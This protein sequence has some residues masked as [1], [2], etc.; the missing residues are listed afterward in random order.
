V[1][2]AKA[3]STPAPASPTPIKPIE[4]KL[5]PEEK[6]PLMPVEEA[7]PEPSPEQQ[8]EL[9][10][11]LVMRVVRTITDTDPLP[12]SSEE[13]IALTKRDGVELLTFVGDEENI[14]LRFKSEQCVVN[15]DVFRL[16]ICMA[17]INSRLPKQARRV[18]RDQ[19]KFTAPDLDGHG[20]HYRWLPLINDSWEDI[21][22]ALADEKVKATWINAIQLTKADEISD[23]S[24]Q[25]YQA[26]TSAEVAPDVAKLIIA[27][28]V[29]TTISN[30]NTLEAKLNVLER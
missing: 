16:A 10:S 8:I 17:V 9:A 4:A 19:L 11:N 22:T 27:S 15:A 3:S 20:A 18:E 26:L 1:F 14:T 5:M 24:Q 13:C 6:P 7:K 23:W 2:T 25:I 30:L 29:P 12:Q 21:Q 28:Q